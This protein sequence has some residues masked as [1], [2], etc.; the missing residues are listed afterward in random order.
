MQPISAYRRC[1]LLDDSLS[2]V[3]FSP[4]LVCST[5]ADI[6]S[7]SISFIVSE[8]SSTTISP[9]SVFDYHN[10]ICTFTKHTFKILSQSILMRTLRYHTRTSLHSPAQTQLS[11]CDSKLLC[12]SLSGKRGRDVL[13]TTRDS[14]RTPCCDVDVL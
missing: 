14:E 6:S 11:G 3:M 12:Y 8:E 1:V 13:C 7:P 9:I 4:Y 5:R 2:H 10:H